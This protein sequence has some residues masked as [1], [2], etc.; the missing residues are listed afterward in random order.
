MKAARC[1]LLSGTPILA[2]PIEMYNIVRI[3]RPD[4]YHSFTKFG[5]RYCNPRE[6]FMG[7]DWSG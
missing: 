3:I 2:R 5:R 6:S 4:L 1:L 7:I